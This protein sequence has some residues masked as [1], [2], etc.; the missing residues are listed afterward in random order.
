VKPGTVASYSFT[1]LAHWPIHYATDAAPPIHRPL[2]SYHPCEFRY[3]SDGQY[4]DYVLV[5]GRADPFGDPHPGP[6][7][8]PIARAGAFTLFEKTRAEEPS[9][10]PDRDPCRLIGPPPPPPRFPISAPAL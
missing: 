10:L 7:F 2:W 8:E 3:R 4:Y 5:Q 9:N 6:E 1:E